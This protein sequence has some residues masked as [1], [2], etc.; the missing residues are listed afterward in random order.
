MSRPAPSLKNL[1]HLM[2]E[3]SQT[4][5]THVAVFEDAVMATDAPPHQSKL[6]IRYI[7]EAFQKHV[8]HL[9][10]RMSHLPI[11]KQFY[12]L[13]VVC[14]KKQVSHHHR[15]SRSPCPRSPDSTA[16]SALR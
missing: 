1:F 7:Q 13:T 4:Y 14:P 12:R 8:T 15:Q 2:F 16:D 9:L 6:V 10:V 5:N 3:E 11:H